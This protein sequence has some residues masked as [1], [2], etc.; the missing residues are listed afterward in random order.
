VSRCPIRRYRAGQPL[1][2]GTTERHAQM[3]CPIRRIPF[4]N[5]KNRDSHIVFLSDFALHHARALT[6][7]SE[8]KEWLLPA[9]RREGTVE[10]HVDPKSITKQVADP[11]LMFYERKPHAKRAANENSLS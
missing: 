8:S 2:I 9:M 1:I 5:A 7:L 11:Q 6:N 4:A 10:T 3:P